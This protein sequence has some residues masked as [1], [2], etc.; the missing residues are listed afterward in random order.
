M[1]CEYS[2]KAFKMHPGVYSLDGQ[3]LGGRTNTLLNSSK[4]V[5]VGALQRISRSNGGVA[6][7]VTPTYVHSPRKSK[8]KKYDTH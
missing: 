7:F 5:T 2:P 3:I 1:N 8:G 6:V 4:E